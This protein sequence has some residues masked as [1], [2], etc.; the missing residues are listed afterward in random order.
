MFF[1]AVY[2]RYS[3][4]AFSANIQLYVNKNALPGTYIGNQTVTAS[5][6]SAF[7]V[8]PL[9]LHTDTYSEQNGLPTFNAQFSGVNNETGAYYL[10]DF[11]A[12]HSVLW[13]TDC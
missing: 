9:T 1:Q 8:N 6:T 4:T 3:L 5:P 2:A 12:D 11:S 10:M 13:N 7:A